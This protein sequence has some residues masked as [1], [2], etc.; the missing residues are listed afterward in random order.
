[1]YAGDGGR[2]ARCLVKEFGE[3]SIILFDNNVF[4]LLKKNIKNHFADGQRSRL[5]ACRRVL[6]NDDRRIGR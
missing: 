4:R 3:R 2:Q 6:G 1:M 5:C